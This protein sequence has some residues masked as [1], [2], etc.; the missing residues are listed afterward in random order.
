MKGRRLTQQYATDAFAKAEGQHLRWVKS[1]QKEIRAEKY[2]GLLDAVDANDGINAG[3]KVILP[4]S[5]YGS[6]RW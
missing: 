2:Q 1:H 3:K 4:P 5:V 6:P